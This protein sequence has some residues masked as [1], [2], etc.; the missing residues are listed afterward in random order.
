[1]NRHLELDQVRLGL[2]VHLHIGG[3][4]EGDPLAGDE[5]VALKELGNHV[6]ELVFIKRD[7]VVLGIVLKTQPYQSGR[8]CTL[9]VEVANHDMP[10][11]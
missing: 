5:P 11:P 9:L 3:W 6:Q 7:L 4:T 1:M 2:D 10:G 8:L